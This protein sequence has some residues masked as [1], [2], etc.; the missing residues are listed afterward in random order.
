MIVT[1]FG[2]A[3]ELRKGTL[4]MITTLVFVLWVQW[5]GTKHFEWVP[6]E[7]YPTVQQCEAKKTEIQNDPVESVDA[8][9]F[10][11]SLKC[12]RYRIAK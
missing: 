4:R 1:G 5:A 11:K 3:A 8:H 9:G 2:T 7:V 12:V 6:E 10:K